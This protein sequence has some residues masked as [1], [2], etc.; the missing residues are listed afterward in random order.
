MAI[1]SLNPGYSVLLLL[2]GLSLKQK[3]TMK[4]GFM[5]Q[6]ATS[7]PFLSVATIQ[8]LFMLLYLHPSFSTIINLEN[9]N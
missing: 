1:P 4:L 8:P 9:V 2:K 3:R 5:S 7:Y 6:I